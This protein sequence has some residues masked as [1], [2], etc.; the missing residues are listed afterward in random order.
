[1]RI[2]NLK[3]LTLTNFKGLRSLSVDF[4]GD[5][6]IYA[7]NEIGKSTIYTSYVW[8]LTGKDEFDRKDYEIKNTKIKELNSRAHEVE[9]VFEIDGSEVKLKRV[10][11][12]DWQ[13]PRGQATKVFKGHFT[14]YWY[15]D[16]PCSLSEY[17]AKVDAI[18]DPKIIKL[19]T[20][21]TYFNLMKW[22]DQ[23]RGLLS[24]AGEI[25]D[26][27][28]LDAIATPKNDYSTLI[29]VLNGG[30]S[31]EEWKKELNAKKVLL[32]KAATEYQPRV[33]EAKRNMPLEDNWK[34]LEAKYVTIKKE[35][36]SIDQQLSDASKALAVSQKAMMDK[37]TLLHSK[38]TVLNNIRF[39]ISSE[40]QQKQNESSGKVQ[41]IRN[42]IV[43][44]NRKVVEYEKKNLDNSN[45]R[46]SYESLIAEKNKVIERL[47]SEWDQINSEQFQFDESAC[48]CPT[49]KQVLP[50]EDIATRKQS[51]LKNFNEDV[52]RR[53]AEKVN[54]SNQVKAEIKQ[55]Q[56]NIDS[57]NTVG[58]FSDAI[59]LEKNT[60]KNLDFEL[61]SLMETESNKGVLNT[62]VAVD[63]LMK[64]NADALNLQDEISQ[65][66]N[67]INAAS[68]TSAPDTSL[69]SLK[70]KK[71][72]LQLSADDINKQ[73]ATKETIEKTKARISQLEAEEKANAQAIA[74]IEQQEFEVES[75][76]RAKMDILEK[77]VNS[78]FKYVKFRLFEVQV[79]GCIAE[80]CVCEYNG[81]PYPTLNTAA[82]LLAGMDVINTFSNYY[83]KHMP[84]FCDNRESVTFIPD[85]KSQII[86]LFV[87]PVDKKL[88]IESVGTMA[89]A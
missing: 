21:P 36:E 33:D 86:S 20:N 24:I 66:E 74:N 3:R 65:L 84:V 15:N 39:K 30:K 42:Q 38:K 29:M 82:K 43:E 54:H 55:L 79:N 28:V 10:Y 81:V 9:G 45:N 32:K 23:R 87:S 53:K 83:N 73:L 7:A 75:F 67:E 69:L 71:Q 37:Q 63:A 4:G 1:M 58:D 31:L 60:I 56:E 22:E 50:A 72:Q 76:T 47:R 41:T 59:E 62:D 19:I 27:E 64:V 57:I 40:L 34:E 12:E 13:K 8:L 49:C 11:M 68:Q 44:H 52:A 5:T 26:S 70:E 48:T 6:N 89:M 80:T 35:I 78:M 18:V 16:V 2:I 17:Q 85:S 51:L 61:A 88:R 46:S 14:E 77:R 25:T